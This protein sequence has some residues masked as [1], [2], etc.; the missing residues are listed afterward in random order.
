[1]KKTMILSFIAAMMAVGCVAVPGRHPGEVVVV[2][3]LPPVVVLGEEP[4]YHHEG[5][6]YHYS[7]DRWYYSRSRRGPWT[8]LPRDHYPREVRHKGRERREERGRE[9]REHDYRY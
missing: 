9:H 5:F 4:Y 6:Y 1:M 3:F 8:D 7:H 2:P